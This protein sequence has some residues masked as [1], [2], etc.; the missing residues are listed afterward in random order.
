MR[1]SGAGWLILGLILGG[2][3]TATSAEPSA[4]LSMGNPSLARADPSWQDNYLLDRPNFA[5]S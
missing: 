4:N 2:A 1:T 3:T 5:T